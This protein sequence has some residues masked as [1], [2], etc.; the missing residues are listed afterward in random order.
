VPAP[1][2]PREELI[3]AAPSSRAAAARVL[4][5]EDDTATRALIERV[6]SGRGYAVTT[7]ADGTQ[8]L[9]LAGSGAFDLILSDVNMPGLDGLRLLELLAN[10]GVRA[11]V[12]L[13][14]AEAGDAVELQGLALGAVDFVRKPVSKEVLLMRVE[15]ALGH[16]RKG[17]GT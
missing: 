8:A 10:Q 5:A 1:P 14:T 13:L 11:P 12:L 3:G 15:R 16:L 4:V 17:T 7:A 9:R 6:L 2:A